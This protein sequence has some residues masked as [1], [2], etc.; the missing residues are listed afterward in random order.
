MNK[1]H[2]LNKIA[3]NKISPEEGFSILYHSKIPK[4]RFIKISMD[5]KD[6]RIISVIFMILFAFPVPI[7]LA[8][9]IPKSVFERMNVPKPDFLT[10]LSSAKKTTVE[11]I[12]KEANIFIYII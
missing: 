8:K 5:L 2:I 1:K 10:L 4:A 3:N 12:S 9:I 6:H 7:G 11:I